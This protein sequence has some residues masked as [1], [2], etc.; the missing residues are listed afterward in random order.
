MLLKKLIAQQ[1]LCL[2][3]LSRSK[4]DFVDFAICREG[5]EFGRRRVELGCSVGEL[6]RVWNDVAHLQ[7]LQG[8]PRNIA[9]S[10]GENGACFNERRER[11]YR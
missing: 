2:I 9:A 4:K 7:D 8:Q 11:W 10:P 1:L 6:G 5:L 3:L